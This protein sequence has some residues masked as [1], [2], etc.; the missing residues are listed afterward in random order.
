VR[1]YRSDPVNCAHAWAV[2]AS[3]ALSRSAVS[4]TRITPSPVAVSTQD[5]L[6]PL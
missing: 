2:K 4:L 1:V 3:V 5:P 6:E